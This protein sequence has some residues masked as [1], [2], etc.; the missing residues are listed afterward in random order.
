MNIEIARLRQLGLTERLPGGAEAVRCTVQ[1]RRRPPGHT[2]AAWRRI[3]ADWEA[4]VA[5]VVSD[6]Q[7]ELV[8]NSFS[9]TGQL[10]EALVPVDAFAHVRDNIDT[11]GGRVD[12]VRPVGFNR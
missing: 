12:I 9:F 11:R 4:D 10:V 1:L 5:R 3:V 7:G 8:P 6:A 2:R